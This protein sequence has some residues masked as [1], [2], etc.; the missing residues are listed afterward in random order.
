VVKYAGGRETVT[1]EIIRDTFDVDVK[2][3]QIDGQTVV[4]N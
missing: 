2:I 1:P 4:L 3:L